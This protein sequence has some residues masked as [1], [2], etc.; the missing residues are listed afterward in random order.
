M[1]HAMRV[2][3]TVW[4]GRLLLCERLEIL[5]FVF[6]A[7]GPGTF[8]PLST[9][10]PSLLLFFS[11][12]SFL[13]FPFFALTFERYSFILIIVRLLGVISLRNS[14]VRDRVLLIFG[15]SYYFTLLDIILPS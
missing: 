13:P 8:L 9:P 14:W 2:S 11:P 7:L 3:E 4:K 12:R 5:S 15:K 6:N 1:R 10:P